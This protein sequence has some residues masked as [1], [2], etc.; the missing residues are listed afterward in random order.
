MNG[1]GRL[2]VVVGYEAPSTPGKVAWYEQG[3]DPTTTWNEHFIATVIGPMSLDV[4]D[5]DHDGD[6]DIIVGEHNLAAPENARLSVF[7][8]TD[9][10]ALRWREHEVYT[11]DEHHNGAQ[12]VVLDNDG[13]ADIISIG[14][15]HA[16]VLLYENQNFSGNC[17]AATN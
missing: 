2:D 1:D 14:W 6:W 16:Q 15:G 7:E 4:S 8:N 17:P 9:Y 3:T 10:T 5:M 11:G 13:D 12:V